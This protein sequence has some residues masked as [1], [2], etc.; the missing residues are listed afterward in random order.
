MWDVSGLVH[1]GASTVGDGQGHEVF[2]ILVRSAI[3]DTAKNGN[4]SSRHH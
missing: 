3:E 2:G 1:N 4:L